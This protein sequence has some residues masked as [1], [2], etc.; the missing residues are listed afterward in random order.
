[1]SHSESNDPDEKPSRFGPPRPGEPPVRLIGGAFQDGCCLV[2]RMADFQ[3]PP[4]CLKTGVPTQETTIMKGRCLTTRQTVLS[5]A[6]GGATGVSLARRNWGQPYRITL[7]L[8][9]GWVPQAS[10]N[11]RAIWTS[12]GVAACLLLVGIV[13]SFFHGAFAMAGMAGAIGVM[14]AATIQWG[15]KTGSPFSVAQV[16]D[17]WIWIEGVKPDVLA[18]FPRVT[19][20]PERS[21]ENTVPG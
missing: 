2:L 10:R 19:D 1:M 16:R 6:L 18:L 17:G 5:G 20:Q 14:I 21:G 15:S 9:D 3:L 13:L 8:S 11:G 7:P 12:G 4:T